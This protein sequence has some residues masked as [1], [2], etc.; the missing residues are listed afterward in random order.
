MRAA[1]SMST[2]WWK[3]FSSS[4]GAFAYS[5]PAT[6]ALSLWLS[7]NRSVAST[8]TLYFSA[9]PHVLITLSRMP[10]PSN[11]A[12]FV[13]NVAPNLRSVSIPHAYCSGYSSSTTSRST[14]TKC[15]ATNVWAQCG[16]ISANLPNAT[17]AFTTNPELFLLSFLA[18]RR[19]S[20]RVFIM[21][22]GDSE[23]LSEAM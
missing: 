2:L 8:T 11:Y 4:C 3:A 14:Y 13:S 9:L 7:R 23:N 19:T 18:L 5:I 16:S 20:N 15:L 21:Y 1:F 6:Q 22:S 12:K 17:R 10:Y